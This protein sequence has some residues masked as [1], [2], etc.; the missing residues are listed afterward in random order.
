MVYEGFWDIYCKKPGSA[1]ITLRKLEGWLNHIRLVSTQAP[2]DQ[3]QQN[4]GNEEGEGEEQEEKK[5]EE[6][7]LKEIAEG[8]EEQEPKAEEEVK[9]FMPQV[10][11]VVR[12]RVPLKREPEGGDE[13]AQPD[14]EVKSR[15]SGKSSKSGKSGTKLKEEVPLQEIDYEDKIL[16]VNPQG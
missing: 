15:K 12:I 11:A 1:D 8:E 14:E 3:Q 9:D 7:P 2:F 6:Q 16:L 13:D 4:E 5:V 10:K